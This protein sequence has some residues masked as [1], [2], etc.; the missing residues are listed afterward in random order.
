VFSRPRGLFRLLAPYAKPFVGALALVFVLNGLGAL[1]QQGTYLLL[2]PTW[3]LLFADDPADQVDLDRAR[4]VLTEAQAQNPE[5]AQLAQAL[6]ALALPTAPPAEPDD[7]LDQARG[8]LN[9]Q[10]LGDPGELTPERRLQLLGVVAI[11]ISIMAVIAA[12]AQYLAAILSARVGHGMIVALR[13]DLAGHLMKLSLG[14]HGRRRFG[15]LLSRISADVGQTLTVVNLFLRDLVQEPLMAITAMGWAFFVAP[16]ATL[17]VLLGTPLLVIPVGLILKKVKKRSTKSLTKLGASMQ[18]LTQML[19]GIRTVKAYRAEDRELARFKQANDQYVHE[20]VRLAK[21]TA[22]SS[23]WTILYTHAGL[24]MIVVLV[25]WLAVSG[26]VQRDPGEMLTFFMLI[27]RSYASIKRTTRALGQVAQSEGAADRLRDLFDEP[28]DI[29]EEAGAQTVDGLGGGLVLRDLTFTYPGSDK[30]AL[31]NFNLT[32]PAGETLALVGPSG[33]GKSTLV[34][35]VARFLDPDEG[36]IEVGDGL[37]LRKISLDSWTKQYAMVTQVPFLFHTTVGANIRYG[38]EEAS[39]T[40]VDAAAEAAG[41]ADFVR[42][43]PEGFDT[44]VED[45]GARLSG[46]QC[47]RITIARAFLRGAPLLLLD[48]ATS[49]LDSESER[50]V[51]QALN[52]LMMNHTVLVVAHRLSTVRRAD[53]IAVLDEGELKE[54]G[55]HEELLAKGGLYSRL[56]NLQDGSLGSGDPG[57][58]QDT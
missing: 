49:A 36:S 50:L 24:G 4:E 3:T 40:E 20:A 48:E 15:D 58:N 16:E 28:I 43:L 38:R 25:G 10:L 30:P 41:I 31:K 37:D 12:L 52:R 7:A 26:G 29:I 47:Q 32:I 9:D 21:V 57:K 18:V 17:V 53:R 13:Q 56:W 42:E 35:L 6:E 54:L 5:D 14:F 44:N 45:A 34:D 1:L 33:C 27:S 11:V 2:Q 22:I 23:A 46:G 8:W 55:T 39:Q 19:Q 51:Q